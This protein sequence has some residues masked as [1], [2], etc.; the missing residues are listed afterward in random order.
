MLSLRNKRWRYTNA[1]NTA[2]ATARHGR[3]FLCLLIYPP[4]TPNTRSE[5]SGSPDATMRG[6][7]APATMRASCCCC[8]CC[9]WGEMRW[10]GG[11]K[12]RCTIGPMGAQMRHRRACVTRSHPRDEVALIPTMYWEESTPEEEAGASGGAYRDAPVPV[13]PVGPPT[14]N[15]RTRCTRH[16]PR[17]SSRITHV[18]NSPPR[19]C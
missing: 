3:C 16:S 7:A 15:R 2:S 11:D 6:D 14:C 10:R 13:R 9:C 12:W 1:K 5:Q 17:H 18:S 4:H 19:P 8:C